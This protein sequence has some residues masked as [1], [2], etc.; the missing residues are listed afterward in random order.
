MRVSIYIVRGSRNDE[1][2]RHIRRF[3]SIAWAVPLLLVHLGIETQTSAL[4]LLLTCRLDV[5]LQ[6]VRFL[7]RLRLRHGYIYVVGVIKTLALLL[8]LGVNSRDRLEEVAI[9]R[10]AQRNPLNQTLGHGSGHSAG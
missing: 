1:I 8:E 5:R 9:L 10:E 7:R 6:T 3:N 4:I 2:R